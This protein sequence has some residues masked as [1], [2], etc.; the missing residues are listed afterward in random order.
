MLDGDLRTDGAAGKR[1]DLRLIDVR[2]GRIR[3]SLHV[4]AADL[5]NLADRA[6][7]AVAHQFEAPQ[8]TRS[9]QEVTTRSLVAYR[10]YQEGL[11]AYYAGDG[12]AALRLFEAAL[13]EDPTFAMAA[14]YGY[15]AALSTGDPSIPAFA[16]NAG[17]LAS[18]APDEE[19]LAIQATL[20]AEGNDPAGLTVAE[21]LA[22]RFRADPN[23]PYLVGLARGLAGDFPGAIRALDR[24]IVMD[25]LSLGAS[26]LHC[27]ACE[28][29]QALV[30]TY[31]RMDSLE[32]A[33]RVAAEWKR[34][35][36]N[37]DGPGYTL[38]EVLAR[39]G[40]YDEAERL[41]AATDESFR[42]SLLPLKS[43]VIAIRA[44]RLLEAD[45]QLDALIR[46][47][48][49]STSGEA[50]QE[51]VTDLRYE[52]RLRDALGFVTS[53]QLPG[54]G[55]APRF[56]P[57]AFENQ[58]TVVLFEMGRYQEAEAILRRE[59][60]NYVNYTDAQ[61]GHRA[62]FR[63]W[64]LTRLA[65]VLAAEGDTTSLDGLATL[66]DSV[67]RESLYAR[68][69]KLS[70]HIRG[71]LLEARGDWAGAA[72]EFQ[73]AVF[74]PTEGY[75]RTNYEWARSLLR[76]G[77]PEEAIA[78]LRPAF[79]GPLD[80]SNLYITYPELHEV[81]ALAWDAAGNSDSARVHWSAVASAW[82]Q[83][84]P[85]FRARHERALRRL[86]ALG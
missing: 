19:R 36:P 11:R 61:S 60:G 44:G 40:R 78:V 51:F 54:G 29:Y 82:L 58:R 65:T 83:A 46:S 2:T 71:L 79:H 4:E 85:G 74:S 75:T 30:S 37:A 5:F 7:A 42:H 73:A 57:A 17:A 26:G 18:R 49:G 8:P 45:R 28:S 1:L 15:R 67:G 32:A 53:G 20:L 47:G 38:G 3:G 55:T 9:V 59:Y 84:D 12:A 14:F 72:R 68:D 25:S 22:T 48:E 70:H 80:A 24:A 23:G 35:Q 39:M 43:P 56:G 50:R 41:I 13:A 16:V 62:R 33:Y 6:A 81:M 27:R 76:L 21:S 64:A 10:F 63:C 34:S 69:R 86:R 52:G 31:L 77:R 66:V